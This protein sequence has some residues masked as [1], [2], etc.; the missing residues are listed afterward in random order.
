MSPSASAQ[1]RPWLLSKLEGSRELAVFSFLLQQ[2][3][4]SWQPTATAISLVWQGMCAEPW[5]RLRCGTNRLLPQSSCLCCSWKNPQAHAAVVLKH[6]CIRTV[7]L[8]C[9][10]CTYC[11]CS[12]QTTHRPD[13]GKRLTVLCHW[14]SHP[15]VTGIWGLLIQV[16]TAEP[17]LTMMHKGFGQCYKGAL[18][19]PLLWLTTNLT[20]LNWDSC[21]C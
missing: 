9:I 3:S 8:W 16:N 4:P 6:D 2:H 17:V 21:G 10:Q 1:K 14:D 13:V 11:T 12:H 7:H 19:S 18:C 20:V 15:R 5:Q